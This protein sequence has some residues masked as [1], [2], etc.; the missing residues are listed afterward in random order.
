MK[1]MRMAAKRADQISGKR[2][3]NAVITSTEFSQV[4]LFNSGICRDN[5]GFRNKSGFRDKTARYAFGN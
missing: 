4:M 1:G 2:L 5:A 3:Q